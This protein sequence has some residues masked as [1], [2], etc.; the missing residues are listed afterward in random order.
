MSI[1]EGNSGTSNAN[2][3][4]TPSKAATTPSPSATPP[5]TAHRHLRHRFTPPPAALSPSPRRHTQTIAVKVTGDTTVE[6]AETFTVKPHQPTGATLARTTATATIKNDDAATPPQNGNTVVH[7]VV[8]DWGSGHTANMTLTAGSANL[9]S[10]TG[11][12]R[13]QRLPTS[14][15]RSDHQPHR[16]PL[17]RHQRLLQRP[18][19]PARAPPSATRPAPGAVGFGADQYQGQR[20]GQSELTNA[21]NPGRSQSPT[22]R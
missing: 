2:F 19:P 9:N 11:I 18:S 13:L 17:R 10:W 5:P 21:D 12:R 22:C 1:A 8:D 20:W 3:T 7:S 6:P 14:G 15:D 4:V 16:Y